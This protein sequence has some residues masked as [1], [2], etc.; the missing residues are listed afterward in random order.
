MRA[1]FVLMYWNQ[2]NVGKRVQLSSLVLLN[3]WTHVQSYVAKADSENKGNSQP[4]PLV[5]SRLNCASGLAELAARRYASAARR[6]LAVTFDAFHYPELVSAGNI[7]VYGA[8]TALA[9]L[10]RKELKETVLQ[11]TNFKQF[12]EL[13]PNMRETI[14]GN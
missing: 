4:E 1:N 6:F 12:L 2:K 5:K 10:S 9:T 3:N 13:E 8:I 14:L 7:A 11:S